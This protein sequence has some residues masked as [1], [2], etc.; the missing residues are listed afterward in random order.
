[1]LKIGWFSTA[2]GDSSRDLL[3]KT[4]ESIKSGQLDARMEF[5]F[6]SREP[7]EA[8]KTDI[9]IERV[10]AYK[11]P[12]AC[13]SVKRFA[14]AYQKGI[15]VKDEVLPSWRLEYD[16]KVMSMLDGFNVDV[17]MLAGYML[18]VGKEMC[19]KYNMINLHPA[20]PTGPKGTWQEVIWQLISEKAGRSG[21]MMHLVTPQ[22]DRGPVIT[23]C[24]YPVTG[25]DFDN[26]WSEIKSAPVDKIRA[27]QGE[28]NA[29]FKAIR[30]AGF[31]R[32]TPLIIHT[33]KA[34]SEGKITINSKKK[35]LDG[36]GK[37][38]AGY[39]LTSGIDAA[40]ASA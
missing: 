7:G 31:I 4:V 36:A 9:F 20:L 39:D 2:R 15:A 5:V 12:L 25:P 21:V 37:E 6:C 34:F 1:M 17:C 33:L 11:I 24:G 22:L 13:L 18:I 30:H 27:E 14:A 16:R 10:T 29:L 23:Y 19:D 8:E 38:I 40:V 26:L 28:N 35:L 32:E 3:I